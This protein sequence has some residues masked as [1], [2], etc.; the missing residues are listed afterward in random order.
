MDGLEVAAPMMMQLGEY[1]FG[2]STAAYQELTRSAEY[3]WAAHE[4][5]GKLAALQ[6]TGPG[7]ETMSL[8]GVI[9]P[10]WNGGFGQVDAMRAE[11]AKGKPLALVD[12]DGG[13][14][15]RWV[16]ERVE[17]T[18]TVFAAGG[19]PRR[20]E[21]NISM[22]RAPDEKADGADAA[23]AEPAASAT[24]LPDLPADLGPVAKVQSLAT[25]VSSATR[26]LTGTL[27]QLGERVQSI[28]APVTSL[29][30][31]ALG[32]VR[33][34]SQTVGDL[35]DAAGQALGALSGTPADVIALAGA[36]NI[37]TR[38]LG[39]ATSADSAVALL[40][41]TTAGMSTQLALSP[42]V[43]RVMT[44][45]TVAANRAVSLARQTAAQAGAIGG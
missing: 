28:V 10:E 18:Q 19:K 17:E 43:A 42:A 41:T 35:Q 31:E 22:R 29:A 45:A 32:A 21:F 33:R 8:P 36:Q 4:L 20:V 3:R 24:A 27:T 26:A 37:A 39:L 2:I 14:M 7:G 15:G 1:Q 44:D 16:I 34:V 38:A 25:S 23:A 9:Y 11:A 40:R 30:S 6:F 13:N 12:G 5:L